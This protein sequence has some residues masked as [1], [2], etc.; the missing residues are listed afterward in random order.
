MVRND[1][2][3]VYIANKVNRQKIQDEGIL[4][5]RDFFV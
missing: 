5:G 4:S 1:R 2:V 3:S